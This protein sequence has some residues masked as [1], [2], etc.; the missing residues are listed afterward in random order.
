MFKT[1]F[2]L[3]EGEPGVGG[4]SGSGTSLAE[5]QKQIE[6][7]QTAMSEQAAE[8]DRLRSHSAK[9][10]DEKKKLQSDYKAFEK[11]GDPD[12]IGKMLKQF[13]NDEDAK[14]VAEGKFKEVLSKHT[15]RMKLDYESTI[16]DLGKKLSES[17]SV[18][19]KY[20][21]KYHEAQA[22]HAIRQAAVAAGVRETAVDDIL[23]RGKGV[24]IVSDEGTLESRD[25][26]GNLRKINGK[27]LTPTLFVES[28]R[29]T[30]PHYWPDS[31][32]GGARGGAGGGKA[33]SNPFKK[34]S[35]SFNV[36]EQAKLRR[37]N[38]E[39]AK[40][41]EAEAAEA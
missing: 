16:E 14:L 30:Y 18:K 22:G 9:L 38:P 34:G 29:K 15:E 11:L 12:V 36:T 27:E 5:L 17:D 3:L 6:T 13:E 41:L 37:S 8:V 7:M 10:L 28:L 40:Q 20:E 24:F 39:L 21:Q 19:A 1:K 2:N 31:Q 4:G 25:K 23:L 32:S 35:K 26:D 33:M